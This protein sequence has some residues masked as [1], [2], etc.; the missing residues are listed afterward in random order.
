MAQL[1]P[2]AQIS[3][4]WLGVE[5]LPVFA[6]NQAAIQHVGENEFVVTFGELT[7]PLLLGTVEQRREQLEQLSYVPVRPIVR[8]GLNRTH[9]QQLVDALADNLAKHDAEYRTGDTTE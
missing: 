7:P 4:V 2:D 3:I 8:L 1:E 5:E 9:M 6:S